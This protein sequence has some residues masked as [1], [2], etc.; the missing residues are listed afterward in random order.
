MGVVARIIV[1]SHDIPPWIDAEGERADR[2]GEINR[3]KAAL[4]AAQIDMER[5]A[6]LL[7]I[8]HYLPMSV[9]LP[10]MGF[11]STGEINRCEAALHAAQKTMRVPPTRHT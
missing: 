2:I 11:S 6:G 9:D 10:R 4:H 5:T 3:R 8:A 1:G 7:I